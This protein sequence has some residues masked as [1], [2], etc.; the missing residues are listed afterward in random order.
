M[1]QPLANIHDAF[2]KQFM[3]RPE[4]A[5]TFLRE[6]LPNEVTSLLASEPPERVPGSFIDEEL[7]QHHADL[8]FRVQLKSGGD[9]LTYVLLEHKSSPDYGT[10]LQLLRYIVRILAQWYDAN[11]RLPLPMVVP[12]V[13]HHG[14]DGWKLSTEFI[15][16]FG[17]APEALRPYLVSFRH[18]LVDLKQMDDR[19]LSTDPRL[20][21]Y[22]SVM[23]YVQRPD[24]P[25]RLEI[26]LIPELLD[27]DLR[28]ILHYIDGGPIPVSRDRIQTVLRHRVGHK[29]SEEIMGHFS[30]E[31]FAEGEAKGLAE[32]QAKGLAEGEARALIRLLEKRFGPIP[33][34]LRERIVAAD[35][36]SLEAWFDRALEATNIQSI[37]QTPAAD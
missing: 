36:P 29:R 7:G 28:T 1:P 31:F 21:G 13:A 9:A 19:A 15:D 3:S 8:L 25:E 27:M 11:R 23:K 17:S 37:F 4:L 12:L 35:T 26:I 14:P 18:A 6:H 32:G 2:F 34:P 20:R 24:L 10:P 5:G 16:L 30:Q 22:L 33:D